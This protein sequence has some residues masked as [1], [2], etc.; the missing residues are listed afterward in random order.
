MCTLHVGHSTSMCLLL[1]DLSSQP[2]EFSGKLFPDAWKH[3]QLVGHGSHQCA[4]CG[5]CYAT[6]DALRVHMR[7]HVAEKKYVCAECGS[8]FRSMSH[9]HVHMRIH[10]EELRYEC[11]LEWHAYDFPFY[12]NSNVLPSV[13]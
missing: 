5:R 4:R 1:Q 2:G 9:L 6:S 3:H 13:L 12:Y 7:V 11:R 10:S 8:R